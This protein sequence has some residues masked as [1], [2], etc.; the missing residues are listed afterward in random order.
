MTGGRAKLVTVT[1]NFKRLHALEVRTLQRL[2]EM[3]CGT[4]DIV[5]CRATARV[6]IGLLVSARVLRDCLLS[7]ENAEYLGQASA[8]SENL[9]RKM[10]ICTD[11][12]THTWESARPIARLIS[13]LRLG[14]GA[15]IWVHIA[16]TGPPL[17]LILVPFQD[18]S[19]F[20]PVLDP[21]LEM[22]SGSGQGVP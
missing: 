14:P 2:V 19:G 12:L 8:R 15:I 21:P 10:M 20:V 11:E 16:R 13:G 17:G 5:L 3:G 18:R 7:M 4:F 6:V 22:L 9:Y 1:Q